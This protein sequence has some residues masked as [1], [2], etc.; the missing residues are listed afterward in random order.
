M[1]KAKKKQEKLI[2]TQEGYDELAKELKYRRDELRPEIAE[3]INTARDLGDLSENQAY[4]D[5]MERKELND[6]RV[7]EL[8]YLLSIAEVLD[9]RSAKGSLIGIGRTVQIQKVGGDKRDVTLVGRSE[10]QQA[11]PTEGK[12]S[13]DSPIGVALDGRQIG[14]TV[15]VKLPLGIIQYKILKFIK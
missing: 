6:S 5:A 1:P 4:T 15:E 12:V 13:I 2:L 10:S 8:D 7:D 9:R 11:D 3:D 14:E